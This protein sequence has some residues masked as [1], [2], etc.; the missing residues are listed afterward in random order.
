MIV[1]NQ[2]VYVDNISGLILLPDDWDESYYSLNSPNTIGGTNNTMYSSTWISD[3]QVHGAV[4]IPRNGYRRGFTVYG[5]ANGYYWSSS[6]INAQS[7]YAVDFS[8]NSFGAA[9][10]HGRCEGLSVRLVYPIE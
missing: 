7:A 6:L 2:Q 1:P 8:S 10:T 4:F 9:T 3:L 5:N